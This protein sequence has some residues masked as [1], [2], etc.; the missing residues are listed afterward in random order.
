MTNR[1]C[2]RPRLALEEAE[3]QIKKLS[4]KIAPLQN[5]INRLDRQFW[6]EQAL[7]KANKYD[8]SASRYRQVEQD[9]VFYELP[10]VTISRM[11]TLESFMTVEVN[12]LKQLLEE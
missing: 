8:L 5:E 2:D 1:V 10:E 4:E 3:A 11:L 9:E 12:E 6:V 7:V